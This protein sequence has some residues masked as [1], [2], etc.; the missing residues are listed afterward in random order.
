KCHFRNSNTYTRPTEA[1]TTQ[2]TIPDYVP[3]P[4]YRQPSETRSQYAQPS[5]TQ[6][7][8]PQYAA[9]N[10]YSSPAQYPTTTTTESPAPGEHYWARVP[11]NDQSK[12][13]YSEAPFENMEFLST[14]FPAGQ[15]KDLKV[16]FI[17]RH[18]VA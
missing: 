6:H 5:T 12:V 4:S 14:P 17:N 8:Q 2:S 10:T 11:H 7:Q 13:K 18:R 1:T 15:K 9:Q 16:T 3:S